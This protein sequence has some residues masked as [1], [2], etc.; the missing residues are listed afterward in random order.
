[1]HGCASHTVVLVSLYASKTLLLVV[2]GRDE[3]SWGRLSAVPDTVVGIQ[4]TKRVLV[5]DDMA[6]MR[7]LIQRVLSADGYQVDVAATL[8][9]A[10]RLDPA[11]YSAVLVDAHLGAEHGLD[12]IEE[13][14]SADPA[15]ARRCVVI[16]GAPAEAGAADL[17]FLAKP[18]QAADLLD[19]V[20]TLPQPVSQ[21][22]PPPSGPPRPGPERPDP[23]A[24]GPGAAGP[25][26]A[27][28]GAAGPGAAGPCSGGRW[29]WTGAGPVPGPSSAQPGPDQA[30]A[31]RHPPAS[32]PGTP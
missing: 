32:R 17:A 16:T 13:L 27:G 18:F 7:T 8:A 20:R 31:G 30:P 26:A 19:A 29:G 22:D 10:R 25:R 11:G 21:P 12:L 24:A 4:V 1:M 23:R 6:E 9:E 15:A 3:W 5:V 14:R 28:P 2:K